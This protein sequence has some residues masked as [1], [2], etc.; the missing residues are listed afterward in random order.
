MYAMEFMV[1]AFIAQISN[2]RISSAEPYQQ[3]PEMK[4]Q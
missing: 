1:K 4:K 3:K 2:R